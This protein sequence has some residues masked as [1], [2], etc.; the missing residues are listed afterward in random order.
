MRCGG[1]P[2]NSQQGL[3]L[4]FRGKMDKGFRQ[5]SDW[6]IALFGFWCLL[7]CFYG[8]NLYWSLNGT[9]KDPVVHSG[10][11][12]AKDSVWLLVVLAFVG[13]S[14]RRFGY[15]R[16]AGNPLVRA[17]LL[18]SAFL[19]AVWLVSGASL[20]HSW[21]SFIKN[22]LLYTFGVLVV[23]VAATELLPENF[24]SSALAFAINLSLVASI[25]LHFAG[26]LSPVDGRLYGTY[27]NPTSAGVAAIIGL[28]LASHRYLEGGSHRTLVLAV[29]V[30]LWAIVANLCGSLSVFIGAPLFTLLMF[31]FSFRN[32]VAPSPARSL[33]V[34]LLC[35]LLSTFFGIGYV[36]YLLGAEPIGL[37]RIV[38][39]FGLLPGSDSFW[40]RWESLFLRHPPEPGALWIFDSALQT[41]IINFWVIG[42]LIPLLPLL[43]ASYGVRKVD[44]VRREPAITA[45]LFVIFG[46]NPLFQYQ[47]TVFPT[48]FLFMC[49]FGLFAIRLPLT[50]RLLPYTPT[51][52][53]DDVLA[54]HVA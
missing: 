2:L 3:Q 11:P 45:L 29:A 22:F 41:F 18:A 8:A 16:I 51:T 17:Y 30:L 6:L 54:G 33:A 36:L 24:I 12:L 28:G 38:F 1:K 19:I 48:N 31:L 13:A 14:I 5:G 7:A 26:P 9:L 34:T 53:H 52:I 15:E 35:A 44:H 10:L 42:G 49:L 37:L 23:I 47:S 46:F 50:R 32:A 20:H 43:V 25:A 4:L 27:G 40:I 39:Q 21:L